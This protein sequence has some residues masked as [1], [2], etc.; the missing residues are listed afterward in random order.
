MRTAQKPQIQTL[1]SGHWK[2]EEEISANDI[3]TAKH[4][5]YLKIIPSP[6]SNWFKENVKEIKGNLLILKPTL[7]RLHMFSKTAKDM[8]LQREERVNEVVMNRPSNSIASNTFDEDHEPFSA[9]PHNGFLT[10]VEKPELEEVLCW[11]NPFS[12]L[13]IIV[14]CNTLSVGFAQIFEEKGRKH[15]GT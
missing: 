10:V 4:Q 1:P 8:C 9:N 14:Q 7:R 11:T 15:K 5:P 13:L 12:F 2:Y 3:E 6:Y